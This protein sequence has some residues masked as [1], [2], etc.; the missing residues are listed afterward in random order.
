MRKLLAF[1]LVFA[2]V[3]GVGVEISEAASR[4]VL[5]AAERELKKEKNYDPSD[6]YQRAHRII[7]GKN[8]PAGP[9]GRVRIGVVI[10]GS[11]RMMIEDGAKEEIY[12]ELREKFPW[13]SFAVMKGTDVTTRL[14]QREEEIYAAERNVVVGD[15]AK[16]LD[17]DTDGVRL[18][19]Y[20]PR[21]LADL[22]CADYVDAGRAGGYDY[23]F[24]LTLNDGTVTKV[25]EHSFVVYHSTTIKHNVSVRVR[26][27][28]VNAGNYAYRNNLTVEGK[29]H[30]N[31]GSLVK[32]GVAKIMK[33]AM[34]DIEI[35]GLDD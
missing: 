25:E 6:L 31:V 22:V 1:L 2:F 18:N 4:P 8:G 23:I 20:E 21:G 3:L 26:L 32:R 14:L 19:E 27:V 12:K 34:N 11:E 33:E 10:T 28:D 24:A 17:K 35:K 15:N 16:N 29:E 5:R 9:D 30:N 13:E 7:Y